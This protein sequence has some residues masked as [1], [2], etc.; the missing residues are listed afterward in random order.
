MYFRETRLFVLQFLIFAFVLFHAFPDSAPPVLTCRSAVLYDLTSGALLYE[1]NSDE[2]IPPASMTKLMTMHLAFKAVKEGRLSPEQ[3]IPVS[4]SASF[5]ASPPRSS[6]MF[7]EEGQNV[8]LL[9]LLKGLAVSSGNDA[10]VAVAEAVAGSVPLFLELMNREAKNLGL[11]K[12]FFADSS[13]YSSLNSTTAKEFARFCMIYIETN[14]EALELHSLK[15]F[16]YPTASNIPPGKKSSLGPIR[17]NNNNVLLGILEGVD[18]LKTGF[19][20]ESGYNIALTAERGGRRLLAVTMGGPSENG[21]LSRAVDGT[22]LLSYGFYY[23]KTFY[24]QLPPLKEL[25]IYKG[26]K[27]TVPLYADVPAVTVAREDAAGTAWEITMGSPLAAPFPAGTKAGVARFLG[28]NGKEILRCDI[29]AREGAERGGFF[30]R[31]T[32]SVILA[33]KSL[34]SA[35]AGS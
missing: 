28:G 7:I 1:K 16:T 26:R 14:P 29:L 2:I 34:F 25:R 30:R 24:P 9:E 20:N 21:I 31:L 23:Y 32:D 10:G 6:L 22:A 27:K 17:Q 18:G 13:G 12:T 15:E 3:K 5:K 19:I 4:A 11:E 33:F 8:T 35:V